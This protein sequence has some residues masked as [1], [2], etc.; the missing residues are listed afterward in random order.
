M[1]DKLHIAL[2]FDE[3]YITQVYALINS[4]FYNNR[5]NFLVFHVIATGINDAEKKG[6]QKFIIANNSEIYFYNIDEEHLGN[7]L[8]TSDAYSIAT[9]YRLFFPSLLPSYINKVLY[10]D[11][12]IIVI[13]DLKELY[14]IDTGNLPIAVASDPCLD[15]R[16]ELN[17]HS[18]EE[19]F[20]AGVMLI[21]IKTWI[22][23]E[24]TENAVK[25]L[26]DNPEKIK[27]VDQ[28]ALNATLI[29]KWYKID[30]RFNFTW[31]HEYLQTPTKILLKD[32]VIIHYITPK[33]PWHFLTRNKFRYLYHYYLKKS[34]KAYEKKYVDFKWSLKNAYVFLRI[35]FKEFYFDNKINKIIPVKKW[36]RYSQEY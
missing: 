31:L 23:Q 13:G 7:H 17:I 36:M 19:Y 16:H 18:S 2:A 34:P 4:I 5:D 3:S 25:Y 6:L 32:V 35:R 30:R 24:V 22:D 15:V 27:L 20:N 1:S 21:N 28:D 9:Y 12:D 8:Y 11:S 14:N 10:L 33:K 29:G 26:I